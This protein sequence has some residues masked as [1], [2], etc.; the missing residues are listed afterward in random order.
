MN[1]EQKRRDDEERRKK[2]AREKREAKRILLEIREGL[3][4]STASLKKPRKTF[5][6]MNNDEDVYG[7]DQVNDKRNDKN[8][9]NPKYHDYVQFCRYIKARRENRDELTFMERKVWESIENGDESM[10]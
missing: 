4:D 10:F 2:E 9:V 7:Y 1:I 8:N 3:A 6:L 5:T